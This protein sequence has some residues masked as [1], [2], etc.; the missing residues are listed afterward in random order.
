MLLKNHKKINRTILIPISIFILKH[1]KESFV[2][3]LP[4][5][6]IGSILIIALC[7]IL[8]DIATIMPDIDKSPLVPFKH[9]TRTHSIW[10]LLIICFLSYRK[11]DEYPFLILLSGSFSLG[12]FLHLIFDDF[13]VMGCDIFYPLIGYKKYYGR[14]IKYRKGFFHFELYDTGSTSN[15]KLKSNYKIVK[16]KRVKK[17][18]EERFVKIIMLLLII[19]TL[20]LLIE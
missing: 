8:Y 6:R 10:G 16:G 14:E 15:R 19:I 3:L 13:S 18:S 11:I 12:Y 20:K 5:N 9:R 4:K 17:K 2:N 7:L 1:K